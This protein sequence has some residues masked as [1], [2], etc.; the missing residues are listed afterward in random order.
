MKINFEIELP[1]SI[2][3]E[4][5]SLYAKAL[6]QVEAKK[7]PGTTTD[8]L[9]DMDIIKK[10][11]ENQFITVYKRVAHAEKMN[12]YTT[13]AMEEIESKINGNNIPG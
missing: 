11:L 1:D 13:K 4:A 9:P 8:P 3:E 7:N 2:A 5:I 10:Q 6:R 12:A